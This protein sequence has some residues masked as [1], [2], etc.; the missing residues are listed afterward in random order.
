[1]LKL[2]SLSTT[3]V[4]FRTTFTRTI[5]L[6]LLMKWLLGSNHSPLADP[7][8]GTGA[9][10]PLPPALI[11]RPNWGPKGWKNFFW[12]PGPPLT[13]GLNDHPPPPSPLSEGLG[14]LLF[15]VFV[16]CLLATWFVCSGYSTSG[17]SLHGASMSWQAFGSCKNPWWAHT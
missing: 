11:F 13:Q 5:I 15:T 6:N 4:L 16:F 9:P 3:T 8:E 7:G 2:Q 17:V 10:A 12:R 1:M 14:P